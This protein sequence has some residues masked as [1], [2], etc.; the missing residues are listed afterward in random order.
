MEALRA[1]F[2]FA[3]EHPHC[4]LEGRLGRL[5]PRAAGGGA[6]SAGFTSGV[7]L[8]YFTHLRDTLRHSQAAT[9][10]DQTWQGTLDQL[11]V[12]YFLTNG[13]RSTKHPSQCEHLNENLRKTVLATLTLGDECGGWDV[14][15]RLCAEQPVALTAA[16][17][18]ELDVHLVRVKRRDS[19][20]YSA[21]PWLQYDLTVVQSGAQTTEQACKNTASQTYEV[22]LEVRPAAFQDPTRPPLPPQQLDALSDLFFVRLVE[23]TGL[24]D[25][26]GQ[27]RPIALRCVENTFD[28]ER[29]AAAAHE[30]A[31]CRVAP[32]PTEQLAVE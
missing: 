23:L 4:E 3:A 2:R 26:H 7:T 31:A 22:E 21:D 28:G 17:L 15:F 32:P 16:E 6:V 11:T 27:P 24:L 9:V 13:V 1:L 14:R 25:E 19:L 30:A 5:R 12:D 29:V 18:A 10:G 20:C 8:E